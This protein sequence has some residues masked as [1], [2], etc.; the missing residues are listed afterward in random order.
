MSLMDYPNVLSFKDFEIGCKIYLQGIISWIV[1]KH[2]IADLVCDFILHLWNKNR[3][4]QGSTVNTEG[5]LC[6]FLLTKHNVNDN[7]VHY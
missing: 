5:C 1:R 7:A 4:E 6:L 3:L 2:P